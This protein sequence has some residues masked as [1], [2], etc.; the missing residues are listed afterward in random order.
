M[1]EG[2]FWYP[3]EVDLSVDNPTGNVSFATAND[4][5]SSLLNCV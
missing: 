4:T 1:Q 5:N 2:D 3:P